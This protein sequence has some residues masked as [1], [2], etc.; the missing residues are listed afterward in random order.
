M[1]GKS[2]SSF[3]IETW[4]VAFPRTRGLLATSPPICRQT[5]CC[6]MLAPSIIIGHCNHSNP[7]LGSRQ[8]P[9]GVHSG[10]FGHVPVTSG[11]PSSADI[12][13][14]RRHVSNVPN[15]TMECGQTAC[16]EEAH[17]N[18][19]VLPFGNACT[20]HQAIRSAVLR[21]Q[22]YGCVLERPT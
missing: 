10:Q 15:S 18:G 22:A 16:S 20:A 17:N 12:L 6:L 3:W 9:V 4:A 19:S 11:Q 14:R 8:N 21:R 5:R 7:T 13:R 1:S 2:C